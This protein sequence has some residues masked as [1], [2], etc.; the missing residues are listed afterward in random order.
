M[1]PIRRGFRTWTVVCIAL[2]LALVFAVRAGGCGN[3]GEG[4]VQVDPKVAGRLG[5]RLGVPPA[6]YGKNAV[7]P[8]G[9]KGRPRKQA[10]VK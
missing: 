3:P 10:T 9:I 7:E 4:T 1:I 6:A 2:T 5:K 8:L